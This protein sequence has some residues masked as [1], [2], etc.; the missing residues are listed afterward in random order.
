LLLRISDH[1]RR[2]VPDLSAQDEW[3]DGDDATQVVKLS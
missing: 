3:S 1:A 2:P